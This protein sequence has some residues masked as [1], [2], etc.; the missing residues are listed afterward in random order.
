MRIRDRVRVRVR[1]RVR[2][3]VGVGVQLGLGLVLG[4]GLGVQCDRTERAWRVACTTLPVP[5]LPLR[6]IMAAPSAMRRRASP[7]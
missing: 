3:G 5:A 7:G 1:D 4:L 2:V 6:R